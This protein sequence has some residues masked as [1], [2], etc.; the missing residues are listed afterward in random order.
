MRKCIGFTVCAIL[1]APFLFAQ[2]T[3]KKVP[4]KIKESKVPQISEPSNKKPVVD[5]Q[6]PSD[7]LTLEFLSLSQ[8]YQPGLGRFAMIPSTSISYLYNS[9]SN[10]GYTVENSLTGLNLGVGLI[11]EFISN[12]S[13][14]VK[15]G[16]EIT[17]SKSTISAGPY[18]SASELNYTGLTDPTAFFRGRTKIG[19]LGVYYGL[20]GSNSL[21]EREFDSGGRKGNTA[22]G[23]TSIKPT[24]GVQ[25]SGGKSILGLIIDYRIWA[26]RK[27]NYKNPTFSQ[28]TTGGNVLTF[29]GLIEYAVNDTVSGFIVKYSKDEDYTISSGT[30]KY[31]YSGDSV[32]SGEIYGIV[33]FRSNFELEPSIGIEAQTLGITTFVGPFLTLNGRI[34]F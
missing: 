23:G 24:L 29:S 17:K 21:E 2:N 19:S 34:L 14:G 31:S 28:T 27:K 18:G 7:Q 11:Y 1:F 8:L 13:F 16:Y 33:N 4:P 32:V 12:H 6:K 26:E 20:E 25:T 15:A 5:E 30:T 10:S 3:V 22:S 9:S